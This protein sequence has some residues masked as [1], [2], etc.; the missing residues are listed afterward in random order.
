MEARIKPNMSNAQGGDSLDKNNPRINEQITNPQVRLILSTGENIGIIST[1]EALKKAE[2]AGLD[3]IEIAPNDT[4]PVC[5]ILDFGKYKYEMQKRKADAR[6]KQ[7]I[8]EVKEIKFTP[9]IGDNDYAV[10]MKAAK[11]FLQEG[12]KVKFTLRFRGREMSYIDLGMEVLR[13]A[14]SDLEG[15]A[16]IESEPKLEGRQMGMVAAPTK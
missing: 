14:Q 4:C 8:V 3:L 1:R 5:K 6:K 7:K 11:R 10:K 9:N 13:R 15:I 12:N 16:K 2:E